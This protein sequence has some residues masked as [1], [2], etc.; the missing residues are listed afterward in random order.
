MP[1]SHSS[2]A[3]VNK[4]VPIFLV[5]VLA[6]KVQFW[7]MIGDNGFHLR[8]VFHCNSGLQKLAL[9]V[10]C[11]RKISHVLVAQRKGRRGKQHQQSP[12]IPL[13]VDRK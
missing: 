10:F 1:F 5:D 4:M 13:C 9:V 3:L 12:K 2:F 8:I 11:L 6:Q 7:Q